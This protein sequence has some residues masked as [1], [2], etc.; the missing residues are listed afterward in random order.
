MVYYVIA[1]GLFRSVSA[2]EVLRC[3][4]DGLSVGYGGSGVGEVVD[5]SSGTTEPFEALRGRRGGRGTVVDGWWRSTDRRWTYRMKQRTER[6]SGC[7][8]GRGQDLTALVELGTRAAFAWRQ[9]IEGVTSRCR[10]GGQCRRYYC[11]FPL[12]LRA[13][14]TG[15]DLEGSDAPILERFAEVSSVSGRDRR[16]MSD[17]GGG[18]P[19]RGDEV[20]RLPPHC[21]RPGSPR[22]GLSITNLGA[23]NRLTKWDPARYCAARPQT[24][25]AK[26]DMDAVRS[27]PRRAAPTKIPIDYPSCM[28]FRHPPPDTEPRRF[29]PRRTTVNGSVEWFSMRFWRNA[30]SPAA[31]SKSPGASARYGVRGP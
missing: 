8:E 30:S 11:G 19:H 25:S 20:F 13:T 14:R 24:S 31:A 5:F 26:V 16:R 28:R 12:W 15:A 23:R 22:I 18:I 3:L 21:I 9:E 1:L 2:R 6:A 17:P 7:R 10:V 27:T 4:V 29:F